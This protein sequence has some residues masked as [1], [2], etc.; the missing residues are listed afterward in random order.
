MSMPNNGNRVS[1]STEQF[2]EVG[3]FKLDTV[4][5]QAAVDGQVLNITP[6]EFRLLSLLAS[7]SGEV[8]PRE[9]LLRD[10]WGYEPTLDTR[11]V[12]TTVQRLRAKL[13]QAADHL[14]T[15][16]GVGYRFIELNG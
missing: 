8:Q 14:E 16:R 5:H 11:T 10:V 13:G 15:V 1:Y 4:R 12:D 2:I 3:P 9:T 6:T 7:R